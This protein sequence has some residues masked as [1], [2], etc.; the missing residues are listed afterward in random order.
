MKSGL[1]EQKG[2]GLDASRQTL[3]QFGDRPFHFAGQGHTIGGRLFL[4]RQDDRR[5]AHVA[6]VAAL[7]GRRQLDVGKL[8]EQDGL[9]VLDAHH[10]VLQVLDARA[11]A[12]LA[13][14][15]F[16]ALGFEEAAAGV[17]AEIA[18]RGFQLFALDAQRLQLGRLD[19][20]AV[21][22]HFAADGDHLG[23]TGDGQQ[24]RPH[25]PVRI[26]ANS[27]RA[28][29]GRVRRNGDQQYLAHDRGDRTELGHDARR[30]LFTHQVEAFGDLLP[31]AVDIRA[32]LELD[33]D[34]RQTDTRYRAHARHAGACR[35]CWIRPGR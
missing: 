32:P 21:L 26:L 5:L 4:H 10:Q 17:G 27:H 22:A 9:P 31:V 15:P 8:P 19:L 1:L 33:I 11:A 29:L 7:D 14:Q 24:A 30:Q 2:G 34:D 6:A 12:D 20:D 13:D 3:A 16:A 25:D 23:D 28:N 35:S 18:Q